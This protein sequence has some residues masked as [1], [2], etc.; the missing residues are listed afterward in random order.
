MSAAVSTRATSN[1]NGRRA[2]SM[3]ETASS[4]L[5]IQMVR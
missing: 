4:P 5:S 3:I 2:W 1:R